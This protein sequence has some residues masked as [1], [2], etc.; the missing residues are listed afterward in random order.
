[1]AFLVSPDYENPSDAG[2]NNVYDIVVHAN[3]GV[4]DVTQNVAVSVT[5]LNDIAPVFDTGI[6]A[7]VAE[8][9]AATTVVYDANAHDNDGTAPN[10]TVTYIV[11]NA[12][13]AMLEGTGLGSGTD[14]IK[15]TLNSYSLAALINFENLT[16]IGAGNFS[17][18]GNG[19]NNTITGSGGNDTLNGGT[20]ADSMNG[21]LGND[22]YIVDNAG[23]QLGD[24]GGRD[25][26]ITSLTSYTLAGGFEDLAY[27]GAGNFTGTGNTSDNSITGGSGRDSLTGN[28]AND[29]LDGGLNRDTMIGGDG[30]DTYVVDNALDVVSE[31]GTGIDTVITSL[32]AYTLGSNL[33][34][35]TYTD[36]LAFKGAGNAADNAI[37]GGTGNDTLDG[38]A[39]ADTMTGGDGN[40]TYIVDN[41]GDVV[42]ETG[43]GIDT[44]KVSTDSYSIAGTLVDILTYTGG[45]NFAGT[46]NGLANTIT[47]GSGN[48]TIDGGA[49]VDRL[50]GLAGDDV[51][52]VDDAGDVIV[53]GGAAGTDAVLASTSY[54]LAANVENLIY[55][56]A[57]YLSSG[58]GSFAGTGNSSS[59]IITGGSGGNTLSGLTGSDTL[60]SGIG[61]DCLDGGLGADS[62]SGGAGDDTYVID[63]SLDT[64]LEASGIGSGDDQVRTSLSAYTLAANV[65]DLVYTGAG[66]FGGTG[67]DADNDI[68]GGSGA[69]TL[70]GGIGADTMTGGDGNDT[71]VVDNF[72]DNVVEAGSG[73]DTVKT[74]L[75]AY[76]LGGNLEILTYTDGGD[77][78]GQGNDVDNTIT[79]GIGNDS[80]DGGIGN[81]RLSAGAG[82]DVL[83]G[84]TG[85]DTL[86]GGTGADTY[87]ADSSDS[88]TESG[89]DIDVVHTSGNFTLGSSLEVLIYDGGSNFNGT[90]N[91]SNNSLYGGGFNDVLDGA[92]GNDEVYA[93]AGADTVIGGFGADKLYGEGG[94]DSLDGGSGNDSID[95][96]A[97]FDFMRGGAGGDKFIFTASDGLS[98]GAMIGEIMDFSHA[99]SDKIDLSAIDATGAPGSA[100]TFPGGV[101]GGAFT[102]TAGTPVPGQVHFVVTGTGVNVEGDING[103]GVADFVIM[104]DGVA[105]LATTDFIL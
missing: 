27:I 52:H 71:Y 99:Q 93:G 7:S 80:L 73:I 14:T 85:A 57:D 47:G 69:D 33:E 75:G 50:V 11:D 29:T 78:T 10:N 22:S 48:D 8:N 56:T 34:N 51:Y 6:S 65:E 4:H 89:A 104:V 19:G 40:D 13:D 15:T 105:S 61:N 31:T 25:A 20:G 38:L 67:N 58:T 72:G 35:L 1:M 37:T 100:F 54:T 91:L 63:N 39:G 9:M 102:G 36:G 44:V 70:D 86:L 64:F 62:M 60:V 83:S 46:G 23:D 3:D 12:G 95:G 5:D 28:D 87:Y 53:E 97:G 55:T 81:D 2:T 41:A 21:G 42:V 82:T 84:G 101:P 98:G 92:G 18:T 59:N 26:V 24:A 77:F 68:T 79:G 66:N 74:T 94:A 76:T 43:A 32:T 88:I 90:G 103:D 45:G 30:N 96:G 17:G 49:G 16:F